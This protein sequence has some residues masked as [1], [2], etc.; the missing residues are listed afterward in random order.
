MKYVHDAT[1]STTIPN[2]LFYN[3]GN[4]RQVRKMTNKQ[5]QTLDFAPGKSISPSVEW[6]SLFLCWLRCKSQTVRSS[7]SVG[8]VI[9]LTGVFLISTQNL[10]FGNPVSVHKEVKTRPCSFGPADCFEHNCLSVC[11]EKPVS[12]QSGL[13]RFLCFYGAHDVWT[14]SSVE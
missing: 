5:N 6:L 14:K 3:W 4:N 2:I 8:W 13:S 11:A 7:V 10:C 1:H 9:T 12:L